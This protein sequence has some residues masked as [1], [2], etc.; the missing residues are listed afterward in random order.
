[1]RAFHSVVIREKTPSK[2]CRLRS[3]NRQRINA[4]LNKLDSVYIFKYCPSI[5][6]RKKKTKKKQKKKQTHHFSNAFN[7]VL[8]VTLNFCIL[9]LTGAIALEF[10][11]PIYR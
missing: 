10:I 9:K 8:H 3:R 4:A 5:L 2:R 6:N 11:L 7:K 1:M